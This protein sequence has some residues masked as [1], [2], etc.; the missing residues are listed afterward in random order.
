MD[1][2]QSLDTADRFINSK[3]AKYM[4]RANM[5]KEAEEMCSRFTREG[6]SSVE[7]LNEMQCMWFQTECAAAFQRLGKYGDALKKCHEIERHFLEITDDQF[8]FHTYCMRKMTLRAYVDLLK[9]EDA[10]RRHTFY[11]KAAK[12]AI[13]IYLKLHDNPLAIDNKEQEVNSGNMS[14]KELK[15]MLSK[16]RR[17]QKKAKLEEERKHAERE[18]QQKYLKKKRD[19]EEEET[20]GP[21]EELVPEKLERQTATGKYSRVKDCAYGEEDEMVRVVFDTNS[22]KLREKVLSARTKV[23]LNKAM[24]IARDGISTAGN[25]RCKYT[26]W[27]T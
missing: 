5:I 23:T 12:C 1:E 25:L 16:Q 10:L 3:S 7:N 14:A 17:A 24:D 6:A 26:E 9:L 21:K 18:R 4:L 19:E 11:F 13:E 27:L 22:A 20:S 15:K 2:A 8:D